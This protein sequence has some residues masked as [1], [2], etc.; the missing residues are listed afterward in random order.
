MAEGRSNVAVV[1]TV[2]AVAN[3]IASISQRLPLQ[4]SDSD[5]RQ[6]LAALECL[7]G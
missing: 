7:R 3:H 1:V 4:L 6:V 2:G 5:H